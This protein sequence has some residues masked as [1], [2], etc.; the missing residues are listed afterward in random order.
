MTEMRAN[1]FLALG[2]VA[3]VVGF[4]GPARTAVPTEDI[5]TTAVE[6]G[7]FNVQGN[8]G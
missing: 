2:A 3:L 1:R 6:A 5:V 4:A 8:N 7:G